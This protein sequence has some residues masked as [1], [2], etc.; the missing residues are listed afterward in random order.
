M[1]LAHARSL[2]QNVYNP[3]TF[4]LQTAEPQFVKANLC[5]IYRDYL[6][7][8]NGFEPSTLCLASTR[9]TN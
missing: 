2:S 8:V 5:C 9:S 1:G 7:R 6:E 4:L 3:S